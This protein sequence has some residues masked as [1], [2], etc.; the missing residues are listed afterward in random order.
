MDSVSLEQQIEKLRKGI[1]RD[2][3]NRSWQGKRWLLYLTEDIRHWATVSTT[4]AHV[5]SDFHAE[6]ESGHANHTD[7]I[8]GRNNPT[9]RISDPETLEDLFA[10][11]PLL[12]LETGGLLQR[13][14]TLYG[15]QGFATKCCADT[16]GVEAYEVMQ[17]VVEGEQQLTLYRVSP[18][19]APDRPPTRE[20][21][22]SVMLS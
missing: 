21:V 12:P 13:I 16:L 7:H 8:H 22:D 11:L 10:Y 20:V 17:R 4:I 14:I 6:R 19:S 9:S 5:D 1:H 18:R 2:D 3:Q 15:P